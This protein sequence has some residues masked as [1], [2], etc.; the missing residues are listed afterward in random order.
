MARH[1]QHLQHLQHL[2]LPRPRSN[3]RCPGR[4]WRIRTALAVSSSAPG[5][6]SKGCR[7]RRSSEP[8]KR[9]DHPGRSARGG[10]AVEGGR[11][12]CVQPSR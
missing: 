11:P 6:G 9:G 7:P 2:P 12:S 3:P 8:A 4:R 5:H 10:V 1:L